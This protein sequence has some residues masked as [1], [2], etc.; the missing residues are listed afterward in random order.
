MVKAHLRSTPVCIS[1]VIPSCFHSSWM[2]FCIGQWHLWHLFFMHKSISSCFFWTCC[3]LLLLHFRQM[4]HLTCVRMAMLMLTFQV[5][6]LWIHPLWIKVRNF[7]VHKG[8]SWCFSHFQLRIRYELPPVVGLPQWFS[9]KE[10]ACNAGV[11]GNAGSIPGLGRYPGGGHGN[12]L[13]YSCLEN[14]MDRGAWRTAVHRVAKNQIRLQWLST[15][16]LSW[17]SVVA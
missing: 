17:A 16:H 1:P 4:T 2:F 12:P 9:G 13:Q 3:F 14:P 11:A 10:S 5:L 8:F 7:L 15:Y 6:F